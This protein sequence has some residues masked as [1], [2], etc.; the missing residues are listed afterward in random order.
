MDRV[1]FTNCIPTNSNNS[2]N[3][4]PCSKTVNKLHM[5]LHSWMHYSFSQYIFFSV[6]RV[7]T[8]QN[9]ILYYFVFNKYKTRPC[10]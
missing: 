3:D 9:R 1:L 10:F 6:C 4:K 8:L 7:I 2:S 5:K